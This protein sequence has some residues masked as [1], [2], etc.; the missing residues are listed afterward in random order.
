MDL[1]RLIWTKNVKPIDGEIWAYHSIPTIY[2]DLKIFALH[3]RNFHGRDEINA[4][5]P[6]QDE[7]IILRQRS[8]VTHIV[9]L[10]DKQFS[11]DKNA[12]EEFNIYRLVKVVWMADNWDIPPDT[13][14]VFD[15]I[16]NFPRNGKVIQLENIHVFQERWG[17][18]ELVF[19]RH[20]Q[21]V[22]NIH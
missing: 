15:C 19:Q 21:S 4:S 6:Q 16:I 18:E 9:K 14:K 10:L 1:N 7:L 22:L 13:D 5:T 3:W 8:K 20:V 12:E 11:F 2:P 17:K